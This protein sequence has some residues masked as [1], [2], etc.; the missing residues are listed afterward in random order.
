[1]YCDYQQLLE[2]DIPI[3]TGEMLSLAILM[4]SETIK[5]NIGGARDMIVPTY[6]GMIAKDAMHN[7]LVRSTCVNLD[8]KVDTAVVKTIREA[9]AFLGIDVSTLPLIT[10]EQFYDLN[11]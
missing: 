7:V 9:L 11:A 4:Y 6:S 5:F 10:K 3:E 1:M 8:M 2:N